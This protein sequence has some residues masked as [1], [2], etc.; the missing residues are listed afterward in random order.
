MSKYVCYFPNGTWFRRASQLLIAFDISVLQFSA[1][2]KWPMHCVRSIFVFYY[3]RKLQCCI[4]KCRFGC[5]SWRK[6]QK[7]LICHNIK[8]SVVLL[9]S[10]LAHAVLICNKNAKH[11][12]SCTFLHKSKTSFSNTRGKDHFMDQWSK[13]KANQ[14]T[15]SIFL[16]IFLRL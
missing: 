8:L 15:D 10:T 14:Q 11:F 3:C 16:Q 7:V 6:Q 9:K 4:C 1:T 2:K 12:E 5:R 13:R